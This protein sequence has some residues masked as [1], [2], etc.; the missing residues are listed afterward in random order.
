MVVKSGGNIWLV[1]TALI[2]FPVM[3]Y[4]MRQVPADV[5]GHAERASM[6]RFVISPAQS[7]ENRQ[8][9]SLTGGSVRVMLEKNAGSFTK[10]LTSYSDPV[11]RATLLSNPAIRE[12]S[13]LPGREK[14]Y[15]RDE[16]SSLQVKTDARA[17]TDTSVASLSGDTA[18]VHYY[19]VSGGVIN[20]QERASAVVEPLATPGM[21]NRTGRQASSGS[22]TGIGSNS[23]TRVDNS[24][25][26]PLY[27]AKIQPLQNSKPSCPPVYMGI[28]AYARNMRT[29]MGCDG[30]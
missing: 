30:P 19:T 21:I 23:V 17:S 5:D 3:L 12:Q 10:A 26:S 9:V 8:A 4:L 18:K 13:A 25:F 2:V 11:G 1:L 15:R 7:R 27:T 29:V 6:N 16:A 20:A 22:A 28:N 24:M 14:I